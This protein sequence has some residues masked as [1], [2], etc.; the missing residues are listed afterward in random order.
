VLA[1]SFQVSIYNDKSTDGS[2][3]IIEDWMEKFTQHPHI[4][5]VVV[6]LNDGSEGKGTTTPC[7]SQFQGVDLLRT[8]RFCNRAELS[9]VF[10]TPTM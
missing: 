1:C 5:S 9:S 8:N 4:V 7:W 10:W 3:A 6:G 2:A